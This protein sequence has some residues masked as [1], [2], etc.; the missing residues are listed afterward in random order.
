MGLTLN[1]AGR[2]AWW[3]AAGLLIVPTALLALFPLLLLLTR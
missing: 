1:Y 3:T 2:G